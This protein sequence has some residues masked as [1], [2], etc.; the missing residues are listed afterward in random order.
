MRKD[1]YMA[2][3]MAEEV[4]ATAEVFRCLSPEEDWVQMTRLETALVEVS[5]EA[6]RSFLDTHWPGW[7]Y[8][9]PETD[10]IMYPIA[11]SC[12]MIGLD[13]ARRPGWLDIDGESYYSAAWL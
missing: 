2:N 11:G 12:H 8:G 7:R 3:R 5:P 1:S 6:I 9:T 13:P 4:S 10:Y